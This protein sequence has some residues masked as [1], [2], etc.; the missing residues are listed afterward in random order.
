MEDYF[1]RSLK[2]GDLVVSKATGRHASMRHGI[3][4]ESGS[5]YFGIG[6]G[7][8]GSWDKCL[9][10]TDRDEE[11][12]SIRIK[13]IADREKE[14]SDR[15]VNKKSSNKSRIRKKD[16]KQYGVYDGEMYIGK[17][18]VYGVET[19][20]VWIQVITP[21]EESEKLTKSSYSFDLVRNNWVQDVYKCSSNIRIVKYPMK[22]KEEEVFTK[23][24][25][26]ALLQDCWNKVDSSWDR[27]RDYETWIKT[28]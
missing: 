15:E 10:E 6:S 22:M 16:F 18:L 11:L 14:V 26:D 8:G 19:D 20:N 27:K 13:L 1:K 28:I 23:E 24:E 12:E 9:I 25:V 3:M 2:A 7:I 21:W 17:C 4:L 5:V